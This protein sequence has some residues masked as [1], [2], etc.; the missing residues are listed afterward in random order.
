MKNKCILPIV[1][2]GMKD[3]SPYLNKLREKVMKT[4]KNQE[5]SIRDLTSSEITVVS[6]GIDS[7]DRGSFTDEL[8]VQIEICII[9]IFHC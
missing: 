4:L 9:I 2:M 8:R 6:G 5:N 3:M 7:S 1:S